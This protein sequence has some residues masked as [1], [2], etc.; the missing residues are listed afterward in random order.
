MPSSERY[1]TS[2]NHGSVSRPRHS[3]SRYIEVFFILSALRT[4]HKMPSII[5]EKAAP[6]NAPPKVI[7]PATKRATRPT[8]KLPQPL[9]DRARITDPVD[10]DPREHL[11]FEPPKKIYTMEEIG[12]GGHGISP[13]AVS[14]PF[15]LF[16]QEAIRQM[17]AEVFSDYAM[18]HCQ[19]ASS[20]NK[21]MV[22]GIGPA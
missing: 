10:F 1:R 18:E 7:G 3:D 22:R 15:P 20:F 16:S 19:Y 12:L 21:N 5:L 6:A 2:V 9:I 4:F 13:N 8:N 17:R 14:E 11:A